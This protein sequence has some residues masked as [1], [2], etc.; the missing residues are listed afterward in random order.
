LTT[1]K[2]PDNWKLRQQ[3]EGYVL[4][5]S[6][7]EVLDYIADEV[8]TLA[9]WGYELFKHDFTTFDIF[10]RWGQRMGH[11]LTDE[12]WCFSDRTKTTVEIVKD[13]YRAISNAAGHAI[14]IGCNTIGHLAAGIVHL[15]RTGDDVSGVSWE[16]TRR[17][18]VNTLAFRMPQHD[19]FFAIDA[20]CVCITDHLP[21][22]YNQ[23]W[24][25]LLSLSGTPLFISADMDAVG[26]RQ[27]KAIQAAL[28]KAAEPRQA[29]EPL[30]WL[31]TTG[32]SHWKLDGKSVEFDWYG[33]KGV[34]FQNWDQLPFY[35]FK[36]GK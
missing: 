33:N 13:L 18:G 36:E 32:P 12:G 8:K 20:D 4:D 35:H 31:Q 22:D 3:K 28:E 15:Q 24:L 6:I 10:E 23:N 2:V 5:P 34:D 27:K 9:G 26:P 17:R 11:Q 7:P 16:K 14:V 19:H 25:E 30:D 29:G 1:E 21:W